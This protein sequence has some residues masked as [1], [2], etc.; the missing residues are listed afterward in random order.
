MDRSKIQSMPDMLPSS[1]SQAD[2]SVADNLEADDTPR[3]SPS[4]NGLSDGA[5]ASSEDASLMGRAAGNLSVTTLAA[6]L[7]AFAL[8]GLSMLAIM[9]PS[10]LTALVQLTVQVGIPLGLLG[11]VA[12]LRLQAIWAR[13]AEAESADVS[14][15]QLAL[16]QGRGALARGIATFGGGSY[17]IVAAGAFLVYQ[18]RTVPSVWLSPSAWRAP[19]L[20]WPSDELTFLT[21]TAGSA[22]WGLLLDVGAGWLD[23]FVFAMVWPVHLMGLIGPVGLA[24][25]MGLGVGAFQL[26]RQFVPGV[27]VLEQEIEDA[28][29]AS[30]WSPLPKELMPEGGETTLEGYTTADSDG[31][32][33]RRGTS[34]KDTSDE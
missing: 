30:V 8:A 2:D 24:V 4:M 11:Y 22:L 15:M 31:D 16:Q 14:L 25:A 17:G 28:D 33:S 9:S 29:P 5:Y 23:G 21:E 19:S 1:D 3:D 34:S 18:V 10:A 27:D 7:G 6:S 12:W 20:R 13:R 32:A 26:A